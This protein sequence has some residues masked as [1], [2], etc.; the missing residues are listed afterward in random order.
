M[1]SVIAALTSAHYLEAEAELES[2]SCSDGELSPAGQAGGGQEGRLEPT[3]I[4][5]PG[6][7][8]T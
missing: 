5:R 7:E 1:K 2:G 6:I 4:E 3:V 8:Q